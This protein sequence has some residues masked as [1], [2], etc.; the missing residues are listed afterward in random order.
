M[1]P[2]GPLCSSHWIPHAHVADF[3]SNLGSFD[4]KYCTKCQMGLT[5]PYPSEETSG[6]LYEE[7]ISGDFDVIQRGWIDKIKDI[8]AW[9]LLKKIAPFPDPKQVRHFLDYSCGN[10]RFAALAHDFFPHRRKSMPKF[11]L[12]GST[13]AYF[14]FRTFFENEI[15]QCQRIWCDNLEI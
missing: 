6:Y 12:S 11:D 2:E 5:D 10:A 3:E 9:R 15:F 13:I 14:F 7:K 4:V 1:D 8:L